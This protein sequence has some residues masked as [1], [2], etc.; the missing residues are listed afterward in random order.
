ML[1]QAQPSPTLPA[2]G[3]REWIALPELA[4]PHIKC[5]VDTG[6]RTSTLHAFFLEPFQER[7]R[8]R[9]RFK[10]H[11]VQNRTDTEINCCADIVDE[12]EVSDSGGHRERRIIICTS[13]VVG[14]ARWPIE[15]TLTSRDTM[16]FRMLLG[17][18]AIRNRFL[19]DPAVSFQAG[20][21]HP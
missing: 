17:R 3:W 8:P 10:V 4:I 7:G 20:K 12:R 14:R 9:V 21:P 2:L 11:P 16:R 5:K 13:V 19:V 18:T 15:L 6:A 1:Q